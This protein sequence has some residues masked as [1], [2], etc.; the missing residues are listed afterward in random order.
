[1]NDH[2]NIGI[3]SN[4]SASL[5][6]PSI[7]TDSLLPLFCENLSRELHSLSLET[8]TAGTSILLL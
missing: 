3:Y 4:Y 6:A 7:S 1:M 2:R 8:L 5:A